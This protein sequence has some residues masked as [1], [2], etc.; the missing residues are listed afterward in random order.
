MLNDDEII[1]KF[2][3]MGIMQILVVLTITLFL[4][5]VSALLIFDTE[6]E[7]TNTQEDY[8]VKI[9]IEDGEVTV[10]EDFQEEIWKLGHDYDTRQPDGFVNHEEQHKYSKTNVGDSIKTIN[11]ENWWN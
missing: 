6:I 11:N 7:T 9:V 3:D 1:S 10:Y 4:V 5:G 2:K 8:S